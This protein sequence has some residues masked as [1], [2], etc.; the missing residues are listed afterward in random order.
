MSLAFCGMGSTVYMVKHMK[1]ILNKIFNITV[2]I[3][4]I[5][6]RHYTGKT[7]VLVPNI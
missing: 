5:L 3:V 4:M 7:N 6:S 1:T 2:F